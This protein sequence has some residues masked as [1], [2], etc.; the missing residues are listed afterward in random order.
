MIL[1][2]ATDSELLDLARKVLTDWALSLDVR[3]M[4]VFL[5]LSDFQNVPSKDEIARALGARYASLGKLRLDRMMR[6][7][8]ALGYLRRRTWRVQRIRRRPLYSFVVGDPIAV[9]NFVPPD[10]LRGAGDS[11]P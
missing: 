8:E 7:A 4:L 5:L 2:P 10:V 3:G 1:R 9:A 6:D 11:L